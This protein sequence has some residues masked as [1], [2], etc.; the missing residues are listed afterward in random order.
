M[1]CRKRCAMTN[2]LAKMRPP[3]HYIC[4]SRALLNA[5]A[6]CATWHEHCAHVTHVRRVKRTDEWR[7]SDDDNDN[8]GG[9]EATDK[10]ELCARMGLCGGTTRIIVEPN[11]HCDGNLSVR[12]DVRVS[13]T[14]HTYSILWYMEMR[15][16]I[17]VEL[18]RR[19]VTNTMAKLRSFAP[20]SY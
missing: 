13:W 4:I 11:W 9:F 7:D 10:T 19:V 5:A 2:A 14:L 6:M 3:V 20:L 15:T 12:A 16:Q 18:T 17:S 8:D 1:R